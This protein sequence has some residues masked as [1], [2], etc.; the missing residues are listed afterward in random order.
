VRFTAPLG[1]L[2]SS[3]NDE[4]QIDA[5]P[6]INDTLAQA[7]P[8]SHKAQS[9]KE[10]GFTRRTYKTRSLG[11]AQ[12][13]SLRGSAPPCENSGVLV[14][15]HRTIKSRVSHGATKARSLGSVRWMSLRGSAPPCENS[16]VLVSEHRTIKSRVSHGATKARSL[17]SVRWMSLRGSAP[18]CENCI[19]LVV[20]AL[21]VFEKPDRKLPASTSLPL[22]LRPSVDAIRTPPK[23]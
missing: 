9:H 7:M 11:S 21:V 8:V 14:S 2:R 19:V 3:E 10:Q 20:I 6:V 16:G 15:E 22:L 18:R 5:N 12:W 23:L 4:G 17:G 1:N 13:M